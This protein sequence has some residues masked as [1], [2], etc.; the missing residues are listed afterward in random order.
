MLILL[1]IA[2]FIV[3]IWGGWKVGNY[4]AQKLSNQKS[5][6]FCEGKGYWEGTRERNFCKKCNGSGLLDK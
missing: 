5:C 3:V 1:R 6:D 2:I 4:L